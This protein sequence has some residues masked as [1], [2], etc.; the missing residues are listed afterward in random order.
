MTRVL[1]VFLAH[2]CLF[3]SPWA[4]AAAEGGPGGVEVR[5]NGRFTAGGIS[6]SLVFFGAGWSSYVT[7][8]SLAATAGFPQ[9]G[10][11]SVLVRGNL[12]L[13][14]GNSPLEVSGKL[15]QPEGETRV[16]VS[17][18]VGHREGIRAETLCV[19]ARIPIA[20][21]AGSAVTLETRNG[22]VEFTLPYDQAQNPNLFEAAGV[23]RVLLPSP[24]GQV[25]IAGDNLRIS[26][27]DDRP[28]GGGSYSARIYFSPGSG[29]IH[30]AALDFD[31]VKFDQA[32][33]GF[34]TALVEAGP[35]WAR[36]ENRLDI[37]PGGVFD[38]S[39]ELEAPAGKFGRVTV[40]PQGHFVFADTPGKRARFWGVNL[41]FESQFLN[42]EQADLLADRL[43]RSG[44][45]T[46]RFHHYDGLLV[47][48]GGP[49][50]VFNPERLD[51]LDY[52]F[53]A[54]KK[55]GIYATTDLF[56]FRDFP[57]EEIPDLGYAMKWPVNQF[58]LLVPVS[59]NAFVAWKKF[60]ANF[61][62][63]KNPYTG[64]TWAEDPA[65]V[66]VCMLNED[67]IFH[68]GIAKR[69][70]E[71][72]ALYEKA[73]AAW[74]EKQPAALKEQGDDGER[75]NRFLIDLKT[76]SDARMMAF[77][78]EIGVRCLLTSDNNINKEAQVFVRD[79]FD[80]VDNHEYWNHP[81]FA[82]KSVSV[83]QSS[84][85]LSGLWLPRELM[86]SRIFG[87]PYTVTEYNYCWPNAARAEGGVLM[88]AFA[89]LQDWDAVYCF[90]YAGRS[91]EALFAPEPPKSGGF[92]FSIV[93]DPIG[94]LSD[95]MA[96]SLFLR[97]NIEPAPGA[98][99]YLADP[100]SAFAGKRGEPAK[101]PRAVTWLGTVT[102][103]GSV[104]L[105]GPRLST[106]A[107]R[108]GIRAF[109]AKESSARIPDPGRP[110]FRLQAGLSTELVREGILP[111][112]PEPGIHLSET[113]QI[114]IDAVKG[115]ARL[116][117]GFAECFV[118]PAGESLEG[119]RVSVAGVDSFAAIYVMSVDGK[120]LSGTSRLLVLHLTDCL[121]GGTAFSD[122]SRSLLE[123]FGDLPYLVK[124]GSALISLDLP[125]GDAAWKAWA[126][127]AS[128]K[129][130][131]PV[132]LSRE[133]G[134]YKLKANTL[135]PEGGVLAYEIALK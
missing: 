128:G 90:D 134:R 14:D 82:G 29:L 104:P 73:Y 96:A 103:V 121:P 87:K 70:P 64:L 45:N 6:F 27:H 89:A 35:D 131:F 71:L 97:A 127:D 49:S 77:L 17:W 3:A 56:T 72:I 105:D 53:A 113:N 84:A 11:A 1:V 109:L 32:P 115:T 47:E 125:N 65:L 40:S 120:P 51:Q 18:Q 61:L 52:L 67:T 118:L 5:S 123:K 80:F 102:R 50:H 57:L 9:R 124:R 111:S 24:G 69:K 95:R 107:D 63:H 28:H 25:E 110:V 88:P 12:N 19:S 39:L 94:M 133:D 79:R 78:R 26:L 99:C 4:F 101:L 126:V 81:F 22:P 7:N 16:R 122:V 76:D 54:L 93:S 31:I 119:S 13:P 59:E 114:R 68:G 30:K 21:G 60:A 66:S 23:S 75:F 42:H 46:V 116:T 91:R 130:L 117:T 20:C 62:T 106:L 100:A 74:R 135:S 34:P 36:Y 112:Q 44:Y 132:S 83:N 15:E 98:V 92:L 58:K 41:C 10:G 85:I 2:L 33:H 38:R 55:R 48:K 8:E 129:R 86:A 108:T 37:E 43:M